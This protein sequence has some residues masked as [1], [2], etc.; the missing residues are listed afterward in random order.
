MFKKLGTKTNLTVS[1]LVI[2]F[3]F[4]LGSFYLGNAM[5]TGYLL[6]VDTGYYIVGI[7]LFSLSSLGTLIILTFFIFDS[8]SRLEKRA[9]EA[10]RA[11]NEFV[12]LASH[13]LRTPLSTVN[14]Y[15]EILLGEDAGKINEDQ[16]GYLEEIYN[17]NQ[18]MIELVNALLYV[19]LGSFAVNAKLTNIKEVADG[20]LSE[21][22][23]HVKRKNTEIE[24]NYEEG[25]LM[26]H[27][28][29]SLIWIALQNLISNAI[30]YTPEGGKVTVGVKREEKN[31]IVSV[32]DN[33]YGIPKSAQKK[34][35]TRLFR[36]DNVVQVSE[37]TGLGLYLVKAVADQ[38]KGKAWFKSEENKGSTFYLSIPIN[39]PEDE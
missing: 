3:V 32:S 5:A 15:A 14:W 17:G 36:A 12:S 16:R 19:D 18:R 33:G 7:G 28:D 13:Q 30:K 38:T 24:K 4:S 1:L 9:S 39:D 25:S 10:D 23:R 34:I 27:T 26:A 29:P 20:V 31:I 2:I 8:I 6:E 35:F 11:K 37:G 21:F 22:S